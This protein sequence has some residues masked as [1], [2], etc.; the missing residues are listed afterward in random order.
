[1]EPKHIQFD[2]S[3]DE[4]ARIEAEKKQS[5]YYLVGIRMTDE[6]TFLEFSENPI[7]SIHADNEDVLYQRLNKAE[8]EF[9][10]TNKKVEMLEAADLDNKEMINGLGEMLM[11]FTEGR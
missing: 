3:P 11:T 8:K 2:G 6:G 4:M 9:S 10:K 7:S 1:M 5:G